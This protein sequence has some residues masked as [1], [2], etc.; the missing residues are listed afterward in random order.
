[1]RDKLELGLIDKPL[2]NRAWL[3][4]L[5][6][7]RAWELIQISY[8]DCI[9]PELERL[10]LGDRSIDPFQYFGW[11]VV[12]DSNKGFNE[13]FEP[14]YTFQPRKHSRACRLA[15]IAL[16]EGKPLPGTKDDLNPAICLMLS[17]CK[18]KATNRNPAIKSS[19]EAFKVAAIELYD[20]LAKDYA[21]A[22]SY[23]WLNGHY[24]RAAQ[25]RI[26]EPL[27]KLHRQTKIQVGSRILL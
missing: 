25:G 2:Y 26:Y 8:H 13:C 15:V 7:Q 16:A 5:F 6:F 20:F 22:H 10:G 14:I 23:R 17:V 27:T 9:Y 12:H 4:A 21:H 18:K 24:E 1:M 3:T 11:M 19:F